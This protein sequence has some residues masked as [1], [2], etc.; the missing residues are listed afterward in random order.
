MATKSIG[1]QKSRCGKCAPTS[2][3]ALLWAGFF[4]CTKVYVGYVTN[5][6]LVGNESSDDDRPLCHGR[7]LIMSLVPHVKD[8]NSRRSFLPF[9]YLF[10]FQI[11]LLYSDIWKVRIGTLALSLSNPTKSTSDGFLNSKIDAPLAHL[12]SSPE[13][14]ANSLNLTIEQVDE[15]KRRYEQNSERLHRELESDALSGPQK[16]ALL[17]QHRLQYGRHPF[18]CPRCWS[19]LP[20]CVCSDQHANKI[21]P[22]NNLSVVVWIHHRE[23]GLT[24]NTGGLLGLVMNNCYLLMKGL[25][26]HDSML[27]KLINNPDNLVVILWP[28]QGNQGSSLYLSLD[29]VKTQLDHKHV[30]LVVVDGTWRNARRMVARLPRDKVFLIDLP[31]EAVQG[32][33]ADSNQGQKSSTSNSKSLLAPLRGRGPL[34]TENQVCTAEAATA[35]MLSLGLDESDGQRILSLAR[36]KVDLIC[37]YRA[38]VPRLS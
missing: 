37:R 30:I 15:I 17:C 27:D 4:G 26:E 13:R 2:W 3:V 11:A 31:T 25:P 19:Y 16:H 14:Y 38:K 1:P 10:L 20:V 32:I 24:S 28:D 33:L 35:A 5:R 22:P 7:F 23:W 6:V 36:Q 12:L 29:D 18:V 8:M 21:T 34:I 9:P